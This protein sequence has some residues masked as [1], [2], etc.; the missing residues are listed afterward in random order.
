MTAVIE[1]YQRLGEAII[2]R[3]LI[4]EKLSDDDA[5]VAAS[6]LVDAKWGDL[7]DAL[8]SC[9]VDVQLLITC[10]N[11]NIGGTGDA[12]TLAIVRNLANYFSQLAAR[13]DVSVDAF[14]IAMI[15][16]GRFEAANPQID[17]V[18]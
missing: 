12:T 5:L 4:R 2:A 13:A 8:R 10:L 1:A 6:Q 7:A 3:N 17:A 18:S 14:E 15:E 16:A 11:A 9:L